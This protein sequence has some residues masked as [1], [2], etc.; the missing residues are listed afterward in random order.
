MPIAIPSAAS[1]AADLQQLRHDLLNPLHVML[2]TTSVLLET[3]L[4]EFQRTCVNALRSSA[5]KL[6]DLAENLQSY[7]S[8]PLAEGRA[9]LAD[10]CSIAAARIAKPFD[11][12]RLIGTIEQ[13]AGK[14]PLRILL[15]DDATEVAVLVR[16]FLNGTMWELDVVG[17]GERAVAQATTERYDLVLMDI[18]LPGMDGATAA[19]AIRAADL[20]R[21]AAPTPVVA[22][23]AFDSP[24]AGSTSAPPPR[25]DDTVAAE[26]IAA[27]PDVVRIDDP[28][29]APLIPE[30]LANRRAD[31]QLFREALAERDLGRV[32]SCAHKMKGS[33]RGY[34]FTTI[35]RI[36]SDLELAA[37]GQ[38]AAKA[39]ALVDELE[40]YLS[41][42]RVVS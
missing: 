9:R 26:N 12:A 27:D 11:R 36:G 42:V 32:Q 31:V 4:S 37:H 28:E 6:V 29:I 24:P 22:L 1:E 41:R 21:G 2:G 18:D 25:G 5:Q 23:T 33:G 20:A 19:H 15:V 38:E 7:Q 30:F 34:G 13:V 8:S 10:L 39:A 14:R 16:A 35:S 3:E 40:S 17:D